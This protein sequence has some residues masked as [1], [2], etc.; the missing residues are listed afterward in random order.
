MRMTSHSRSTERSST[1]VASRLNLEKL[2]RGSKERLQIRDAK[3][4][5]CDSCS[6]EGQIERSK[7][8]ELFPS[9]W[10]TARRSFGTLAS[11]PRTPFDPCHPSRLYQFYPHPVSADKF[12]CA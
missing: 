3:N 11:F 12:L 5:S 4:R 1:R 9:A 10:L 8:G 2:C 6:K 7:A